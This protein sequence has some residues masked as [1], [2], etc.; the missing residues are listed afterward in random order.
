MMVR[1]LNA[2]GASSLALQ[3]LSDEQIMVEVLLDY[4]AAKVFAVRE[5]GLLSSEE[6]RARNTTRSSFLE[7]ASIRVSSY[8]SI[9]SLG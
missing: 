8:S 6:I 3:D 2:L 4:F 1:Q 9:N 5:V 7:N